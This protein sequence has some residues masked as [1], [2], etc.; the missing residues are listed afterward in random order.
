MHHLTCVQLFHVSP[1]SPPRRVAASPTGAPLGN[2]V[3]GS[4][5]IE[6]AVDHGAEEPSNPPSRPSFR[7]SPALP[8]LQLLPSILRGSL[9]TP[10]APSLWQSWQ[11][12]A[13]SIGYPSWYVTPNPPHTITSSTWRSTPE[14][15]PSLRTSRRPIPPVGVHTWESSSRGIGAFQRC[16]PRWLFRHNTRRAAGGGLLASATNTRRTA[17]QNPG[18][19]PKGPPCVSLTY[20]RWEGTKQ[21][22]LIVRVILQRKTVQH[23]QLL[24]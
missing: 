13:R 16:I 8:P 5:L 15:A 12:T 19:S 9:R 7:L 18:T 22:E 6:R 21:H 14:A 23:Q 3:R 24:V 17:Q 11:L 20:P 2:Q 10:L 1:A 4:Q